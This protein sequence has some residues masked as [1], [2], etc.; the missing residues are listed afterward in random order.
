[1]DI[2]KEQKYLLDLISFYLFDE[3]FDIL[4]YPEKDLHLPYLKRLIKEQKMDGL[5]FCALE[6]LHLKN[7][8]YYSLKNRYMQLVIYSTNQDNEYQQIIQLLDN[9]HIQYVPLKGSF[10]KNYYPHHENRLMGDIDILIPYE[11]RKEVHQL[12]L[13]NGY[14]DAEDAQLSSHHEIFTHGA[15]GHFEIHFRLLDEECSARDYLDKIVWDETFNHQFT[16]EFNLV[17]QLA[18]YANHFTHG[19]ASF[20]S[21]IDIALLLQKENMN[22]EKLYHLLKES[23][24]ISFYNHI[25]QLIE[26]IFPLKVL[27]FQKDLS[28][29]QL[30]QIIDFIFRC[31]DFGFGKDNDFNYQRILYDFSSKKKIT[32]ASK[33]KYI[34]LQVC[35]PYRKFKEISKTIRYCPILLPF[36]WLVR[37]IKYSFKYKGKVKEKLKNISK[38]SNKDIEKY[39]LIHHFL[40]EEGEI[41]HEK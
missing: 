9:H 24:Q 41:N 28:N 20:K 29:E 40:N 7:D 6:K 39:Q 14:S 30:N 38:I 33:L 18:H 26:Y 13:E 34:I 21:F 32:K 11:K 2:K 1:M 17:Y 25:A 36:G 37:L 15:Y 22:E 27:C 12:L 19:G 10:M 8:L 3:P 23:K 16:N 31:G 5:I 35:I 4:S